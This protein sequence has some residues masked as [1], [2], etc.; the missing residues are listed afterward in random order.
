MDAEGNIY[1]AMSEMGSCLRK[2]APDGKL[3]WELAGDFFVDVVSADPETDALDIWGIKEHYR[4]DFGAATGSGI[5]SGWLLP[6][7]P[8]I[9]KRPSRVDAL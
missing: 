7:S 2:F 8:S 1:V 4:M 5:A 3:L 6:G 9:P